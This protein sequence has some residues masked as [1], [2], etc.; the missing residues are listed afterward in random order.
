MRIAMAL[1][2]VLFFASAP[3][4]R[5]Q[6]KHAAFERLAALVMDKMKE[7]RVPGAALGILHDGTVTSRGFGVT[8]IDH[9]LPVTDR[10]LFQIGSI[11]KTFTGTAIMR[12]VE[13]GKVRLDAPV[14]TY[15]PAFAVRDATASRDVTVLDLLTHMGGWEGDVFEDTGEGTD[16]LATYVAN[17]KDVEQVAPL[18]AVWSYNNSGFVVAGRVIEVVTGKTYEDAL[19]E[20]VTTPLALND[21][22]I[23]PSDVMTLRFAAGHVDG[24]GGPRV[25]RPWPIGR[26]AH[27]AGGVISTPR[28]LLAYAQFHMGNGAPLFSADTLGRMHAAVLTKHATD[29]QM[30]VTWHVANGGGIR[31]ISH[32]G[33]TL[34]QQSMLMLVPERKFAVAVVVNSGG[35]LI[36]DVVRAAFKEFLDI[37]DRDPAPSATQPDLSAYTGRYTRPFADVLVSVDKGTM[38]VQTIRKGGFPNAS[39]PVPPPGPKVPYAFFA[40]DNAIATAA[41]SGPQAGARIQFVRNPDGTIGWVRVGGRI[42]RKAS[43]STAQ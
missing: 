13:R 9:P 11:S 18:R 12:L 33:G 30:A 21:T 7:Y 35:R 14:R 29:E 31:R 19:R 17:L 39:A 28:D 27:P 41:T 36:Q 1:A 3:A 4:P 22:Y 8:N 34:G 32:G 43:A 37:E 15:L 20:L 2:L 10:T 24:P 42:A 40:K 38:L 23:T 6:E 25:A 16:A 26:Y 5:D